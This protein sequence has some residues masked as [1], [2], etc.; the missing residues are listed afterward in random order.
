L[1]RYLA[2]TKPQ[3]HR[4]ILGELGIRG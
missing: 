4:Q 1:L 2:R 3:A